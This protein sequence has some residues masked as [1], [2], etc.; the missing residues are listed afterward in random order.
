[1]TDNKCISCNLKSVCSDKRK[2]KHQNDCADY[3]YL[4][5]HA[6]YVGG[7]PPRQFCPICVHKA[8]KCIS[9]LDIKSYAWKCGCSFE[10]ARNH[11][12]DD[13]GYILSEYSML[14][15]QCM[16]DCDRFEEVE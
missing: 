4:D 16:T 15:G 12:I 5:S 14:E 13:L 10:Q 3:E 9:S 1:M 6:L 8:D 2:T 11:I 7:S